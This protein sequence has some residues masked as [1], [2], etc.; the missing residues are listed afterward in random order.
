M[1]MRTVEVDKLNNTEYTDPFYK[2][3]AYQNSPPTP[4]TVASSGQHNMNHTANANDEVLNHIHKMRVKMFEER[5][6]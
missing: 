1:A 4:Q 3:A 5:T 2:L 6:A